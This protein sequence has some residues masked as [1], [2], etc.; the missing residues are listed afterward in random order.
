MRLVQGLTLGRRSQGSATWIGRGDFVWALEGLWDHKGR[1]E[2]IPIR[3]VG[4]E[5]YGSFIVVVDGDAE[6][7]GGPLRW[8]GGVSAEN[9]AG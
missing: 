9:W 2:P 5:A 4:A 6:I 7:S 1:V 3:Q 8:Q